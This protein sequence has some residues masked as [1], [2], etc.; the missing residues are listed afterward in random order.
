MIDM[1]DAEYTM[2]GELL[3]SADQS[4]QAKVVEA[5]PEKTDRR[6][7]ALERR[8]RHLEAVVHRLI[9]GDAPHQRLEVNDQDAMG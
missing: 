9:N 1:L 4:Q 5:W 6:V 8:V 2:P 7:D 3:V